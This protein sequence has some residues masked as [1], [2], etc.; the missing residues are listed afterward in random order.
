MFQKLFDRECISHTWP[1]SSSSWQG[2]EWL[3]VT[4]WTEL[5][6]DLRIS[7][8][9]F[10]YDRFAYS[11]WREQSSCGFLLAHKV[12]QSSYWHLNTNPWWKLTDCWMTNMV[13]WNGI[14]CKKFNFVLVVP[15][16]LKKKKKLKISQY[17]EKLTAT[18]YILIE[19]NLKGKILNIGELLK[20]NWIFNLSLISVQL[21]FV[22]FFHSSINKNFFQTD[23]SWNKNN[24]FW[25]LLYI[26]TLTFL[27][28]YIL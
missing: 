24:N 4:S 20:D 21:F 17:S 7:F 19:I 3:V 6:M 26:I 28:L 22:L 18:L 13:S 1:H 27:S 5:L 12:Q 15:I 16:S 9:R 10:R 14:G 25:K 2:Y 8:A 23:K 11:G